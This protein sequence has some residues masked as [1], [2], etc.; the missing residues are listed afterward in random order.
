MSSKCR[1][2]FFGRQKF[3]Y[4][5]HYLHCV[6]CKRV[7]DVW[8]VCFRYTV[9][10]NICSLICFVC[11]ETEYIQGLF[12]NMAVW[13]TVH[14][15]C[16]NVLFHEGHLLPGFN[17]YCN[18]KYF[19]FILLYLFSSCD[20]YPVSVYSFWTFVLSVFFFLLFLFFFIYCHKYKGSD[21]QKLHHTLQFVHLKQ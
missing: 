6:I 19:I 15:E 16:Q 14:L 2:F 11:F 5:M 3:P 21:L 4:S 12:F 9:P 8:I 17:A 10:L 13:I 1:Y 20:M 7:S 18:L